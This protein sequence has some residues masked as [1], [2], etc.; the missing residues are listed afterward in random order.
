MRH[1][2]QVVV[3]DATA[4]PWLGVEE[5]AG[6]V[7]RDGDSHVIVGRRETLLDTQEL[8]SIRRSAEG[9]PRR[10]GGCGGGGLT[11]ILCLLIIRSMSSLIL[12]YLSSNSGLWPAESSAS[13]S[14]LSQPF[15]PFLRSV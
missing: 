15:R 12:R 11:Q 8:V 13:M 10:D 5:P 4:E 9:A 2:Q 14:G 1:G 6:V 7:S 3:A